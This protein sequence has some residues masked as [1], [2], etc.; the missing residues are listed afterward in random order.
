MGHEINLKGN[1]KK[2]ARTGT[3]TNKQIAIMDDR[4]VSR[5]LKFKQYLLFL[6]DKLDIELLQSNGAMQRFF[7]EK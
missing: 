5:S 6:Y 1:Q 3:R 2:G 7:I 4:I